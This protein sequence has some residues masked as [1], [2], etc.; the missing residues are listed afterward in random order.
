MQLNPSGPL[1]PQL[2]GSLTSAIRG[3]GASSSRE[4]SQSR[5]AGS[6]N[7]YPESTRLSTA[8]SNRGF[9]FM[10][11]MRSRSATPS[12][13][14]SPFPGPTPSQRGSL[15]V[16]PHYSRMLTPAMGQEAVSIR[17]PPSSIMSQG[18]FQ[19]N[20]GFTPNHFPEDITQLPPAQPLRGFITLLQAG[21][22]QFAYP[23][24]ML[25]PQYG[26]ALPVY[27]NAQLAV[28]NF[29]PPLPSFVPPQAQQDMQFAGMN[30]EE[31]DGSDFPDP[32]STKGWHEFIPM[33][34]F[35]NRFADSASVTD[36]GEALV[37]EADKVKMKSKRLVDYPIHKI[38]PTDFTETAAAYPRAIRDHFIPGKAGHVGT[39]KAL[40]IA[41]MFQGLFLST[42]NSS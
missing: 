32:R 23:Q 14:A 24:P 12:A 21:A 41:D 9:P 19:S 26:V 20:R 8:S 31:D 33:A 38:T 25:H 10:G 30:V 36:E 6:G 1:I 13:L 15:A 28:Q 22:Q 39:T 17:Q 40:A 5:T 35:A 29:T 37:F 3:S 4:Q 16:T 34:Y 2:H 27:T 7:P 11:P 42:S 18:D